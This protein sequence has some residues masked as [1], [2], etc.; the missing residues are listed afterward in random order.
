MKDAFPPKNPYLAPVRSRHRQFALLLSLGLG[1]CTPAPVPDANTP[2]PQESTGGETSESVAL[3]GV[4]SAADFREN[5]GLLERL[6]NA[7]YGYYRFTNR[8]FADQVCERF[9][10][11]LETMPTVNL[12]GDAHLEQYAVTTDSRGLADYDD[13]TAGPAVLDLVRFG[14]SIVLT[15]ELRGW[16]AGPAV[17]AFFN[18]YRQALDNPEMETTAPGFVARTQS[19]FESDRLVYLQWAESLMEAPTPAQ[20]ALFERSYGRYRE[21]MEGQHPDLPEHF[22]NPKAHGRLRMGFGSAMAVKFLIRAEGPTLAPEDDVILEAKELSDLSDVR[23]LRGTT[24]GGAFRVLVGQA[25]IS[26][27]PRPYLANVPSGPENDPRFWVHSWV[28]NY[29]ELDILEDLADFDE[30]LTICTDVGA[31][32]GRG[33]TRQIAAPY[34]YQLRHAVKQMLETHEVAIREAIADM[35]E[36]TRQSWHT[37][38]EQTAEQ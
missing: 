25:R 3:H 36:V 9:E 11:R 5:P 14:A 24:G 10:D 16:E 1:A 18:G 38:Q 23:C 28:D 2:D 21:L 13:A 37:F 15:A 12:H 31:Q 33:H 8:G 20:E 7:L 35:A 17:D 34:D 6:Q 29:R 19:T 22:F 27:A 26:D 32:L 30:L 4:M